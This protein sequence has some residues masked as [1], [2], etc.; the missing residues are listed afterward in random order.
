MILKS[1]ISYYVLRKFGFRREFI[2]WVKILIKNA[3]SCI[4][5]NGKTTPCFKLEKATRQ[6]DP[7][8]AYLFI[9]ELEVTFT[10][11]LV[12]AIFYRIFIFHQM[13]AL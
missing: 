12:S 7:T 6:E 4:I 9:L 2:K 1:I 11:K 3:E 10:L 13:T 5:N 8:S